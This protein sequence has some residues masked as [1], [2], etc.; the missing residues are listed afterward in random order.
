[1][2]LSAIARHHARP[3]ASDSEGGAAGPVGT[4]VISGFIIGSGFYQAWIAAIVPIAMVE[5]SRRNLRRQEIRGA[6]SDVLV[7]PTPTSA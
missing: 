7:E 1:M 6:L 2:I 3:K 5:P 4:P